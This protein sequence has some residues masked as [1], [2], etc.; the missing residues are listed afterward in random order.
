MHVTKNEN[1]GNLILDATVAPADIKYPTDVNILNK[2]RGHLEKMIGKLH[3]PDIGKKRIPRTYKEKARK[4]YLAIEKKRRKPKK[5]IQIAIKKQ[6]SYV[7][8][9]LNYVKRYLENTPERI[10]L[11]SQ[12][13]LEKLETIKKIY[14]QQKYMYES[15][16]RKVKDRIVS[17]HQPYI[18]PIVRGKA[19]KRVEFGCKILTSVIDSFSFIEHMSFD[20]FNEGIYLKAAVNTYKKRFGYY[21]EAVMADTIFRNR[22]NNR[23]LKERN[24]RI[25]GPRLGRPPKDK[26]KQ[27]ARRKEIKKD[28][29]IR[30]QVEASYGTA[31]RFLGLDLIKSK[32]KETNKTEISIQF[33]L[34]NLNKLSK[35]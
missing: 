23:W 25:S 26:E 28:S 35:L 22:E 29:G 5:S 12:V 9:D 20:N 2:S 30:N 33:L 34:L 14:E 3:A 19:G 4:D 31:K 21:P 16:V 7:K 32:T 18:R 15:D 13:D 10:K 24:I 6:L 11:L 17:L 8:R 27:A 1:Y